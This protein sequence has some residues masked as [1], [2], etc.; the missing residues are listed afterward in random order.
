MVNTEADKA[1][2]LEICN[3]HISRNGFEDLLEWL[4]KSDFYIA[5]ASTK[6]HL[7][8]KGGLLRHSLNVYDEM[9]RLCS[10]YS[11]AVRVSEES[12]AIMA[13]LHDLCKVNFYK[14]DTRN[15]KKDG[16]C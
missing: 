7:S 14:P 1:R 13:L 2:F 15:V 3:T 9:K 16:V 6:Y 10:T 11:H 12:I 8:E 4:E 5:P